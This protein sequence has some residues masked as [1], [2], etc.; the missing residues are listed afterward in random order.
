MTQA[1]DGAV[2]GYRARIGYTCPPVIAEVFPYEFYKVV[3]Q[4]ATKPRSALRR[5]L[6]LKPDI[7]YLLS[8]GIVEARSLLVSELDQWNH[9]RLTRIFTIAYLDREGATLLE[10]IAREHNGEF[11]FV[12]EHDLP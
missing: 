12:T 5:A 3:P 2:Y 1:T 6:A 9:D 11:R 10:Q 7:L 8:D 4:G